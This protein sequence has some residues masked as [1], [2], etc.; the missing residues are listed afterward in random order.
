[1]PYTEEIPAALL[2]LAPSG[3]AT[4]VSSSLEAAAQEIDEALSFAGLSV[5]LDLAQITNVESRNRFLAK[6]R[7]TEQA[8]AARLLSSAFI[9]T[10]RSKSTPAKVVK[11]YEIAQKWLKSIRENGL[12]SVG[13]TISKPQIGIIGDQEWD[14]NDH[15]DL[16]SIGEFW[17]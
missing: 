6:I 17:V 2:S 11:D 10:D 8:I 16:M 12:P 15:Y 7:M 9:S 1:M 14:T 13:L 5:P 4:A 3:D